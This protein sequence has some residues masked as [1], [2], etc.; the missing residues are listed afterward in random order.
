MKKKCNRIFWMLI[1]FIL[2]RPPESK[3]EDY[4][5]VEPNIY[6]ENEI[7]IPTEYFH[8]NSYLNR[9]ARLPEEQLLLTFE[10][11]ENAQLDQIETA[12]FTSPS[13]QLN[14]I[15]VKAS[16]LQLFFKESDKNTYVLEDNELMEKD[17][18]MWF[19]VVL[20]AIVSAIVGYILIVLVPKFSQ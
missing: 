16:N 10:Q 11:K 17:N 4:I 5:P 8:E 2:L 18:S 9:K 3:A 15:S 6:E 13:N 7:T 14:T 1:L 20:G 19:S 12:L